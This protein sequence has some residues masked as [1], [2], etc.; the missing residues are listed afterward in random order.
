M[1]ACFMALNIQIQPNI[2]PGDKK[3]NW[4]TQMS[5]TTEDSSQILGHSPVT[6]W[7]IDN[8]IISL[9]ER[10]CDGGRQS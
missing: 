8:F 4:L 3:A 9:L 7:L 5:N 2:T 1:F 6:L 10:E